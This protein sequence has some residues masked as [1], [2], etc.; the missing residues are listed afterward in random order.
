[1][2]S[3]IDHSDQDYEIYRA[4]QIA[5]IK[6]N[7]ILSASLVDPA[8]Q[9][10]KILREVADNNRIRWLSDNLDVQFEG[11]S[12]LLRVSMTLNAPAEDLEAMV[13]AVCNAYLEEVIIKDRLGREQ[14]RDALSVTLAKLN[15]EVRGKWAEYKTYASDIKSTEDDKFDPEVKMMFSQIT[16]MVSEQSRLEA[17]IRSM[18]LEYATWLEYHDN[19]ALKEMMMDQ[20]VAANQELQFM[21]Q[22]IMGLRFRLREAEQRSKNRVTGETK[23]IHRELEALQQSK[24]SLAGEIRQQIYQ[25]EADQPDVEG[26]LVKKTFQMKMQMAAGQLQKLTGWDEKQEDG[27]IKHI[28]GEIDKIQEEL[29]GKAQRSTELLIRKA[30]LDQLQLVSQDLSRRIE[31]WGI[32]LKAAPR[33]KPVHPAV[34]TPGINK[35]QRYAIAGLGGLGTLALTF[36]GIAYLEFMGR[37]LNEPEQ[38]DEGLGLRVVGTL[39]SLNAKRLSNPNHPLVAQLTESIDSVRTALMHDSTSKPRKVVLVTSPA[40]MEGRTTVASQLAASLARAGRRTLLIDGDMR[41]PA[42]HSLFDVPLEDGLCEVLRAETE[43]SDVVR[44]THAEGL[45]LMTAGYCDADAVHAMATD[46]IQPIFEKLRAD[47]D[48]VIIDGAP[49]LGLSDSLMMGQHCDGALLSV[50]RDH[51]TV[52]KIHQAIELL[53]GVG[54]RLIGSVVNGVSSKADHRVTHLQSASPKSERKQLETSK[55]S[56]TGEIFEA[57]EI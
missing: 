32:E 46:Q 16:A 24:A 53:R 48:F 36:F 10:V 54:I 33:I 35:M 25:A 43:V 37:R 40:T 4:T 50:L 6:D 56:E 28:P 19:P 17:E 57:G 18:R 44:A 20:Q 45:W 7:T 55:I 49:V 30:E 39:P 11:K 9:N 52:P 15:E 12:E 31:S 51:T 41:R 1:M 23:R 38:V 2:Y 22:Q 21:D 3:N 47:Y 26:G 42:L 13:N 5:L 34:I 27:T 8:L 14:I 29:Q